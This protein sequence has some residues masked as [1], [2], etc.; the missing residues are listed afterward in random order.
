[1]D[2]TLLRQI[3]SEGRE[4]ISHFPG[5]PR[6]TAG[7][8]PF[9]PELWDAIIAV[10]EHRWFWRPDRIKFVLLAES[11]VYTDTDD[12]QCKITGLNLPPEAQKA[13]RQFV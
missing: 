5:P 9:V 4:L 10:E 3:Y 6:A 8:E 1:M 12:L 7:W 11:H 13:P 2:R